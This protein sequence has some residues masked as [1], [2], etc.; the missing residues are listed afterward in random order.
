MCKSP[1]FAYQ[2]YPTFC[3]SNGEK[4]KDFSLWWNKNFDHKIHFLK[5][6]SREEFDLLKQKEN[7]LYRFVE[8]P[9][10]NCIECRL[11]KSRDWASRIVCEQM[12]SCNSVF[13]TLTYDDDHLPIGDHFL[14]TLVPDD[15]STFFKDLRRYCEY[16]FGVQGIRHYTAGEYGSVSA[17]P[18]YHSCMFNLPRI[19]LEQ[20]VPYKV[21]FNGDIYYNNPILEKIWNKGFVVIGDLTYQSAAY[22]ARYVVK[23]MKGSLA[24]EKYNDCGIVPEF[25]RMSRKPGIGAKYFDLMKD[26]IYKYDALYLPKIG[27]VKPSAYFDKKFSLDEPEVLEVIKGERSLSAQFRKDFILSRTDLDYDTYLR[28]EEKVLENRLKKLVR[29]LE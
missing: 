8:V 15:V 10:G 16:H 5:N 19:L 2:Y 26:D 4:K 18:H 12:T 25:A 29:P 24:K 14:P 9:C 6:Q 17:R 22:V 28:N 3:D 27:K 23:K 20:N 13:V 1:L 21:S 7:D 11:N